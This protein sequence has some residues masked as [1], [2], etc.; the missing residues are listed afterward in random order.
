MDFDSFLKRKNMIVSDLAQMLG[1]GPAA[2]Y[3]YKYSKSKPSY[4]VIEKMLI[5][6]ARIQPSDPKE[7]SEIV[8]QGILDLLTK[9]QL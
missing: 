1:V 5:A 4:D 7:Y 2:V 3:N 9:N 6:G 8:R